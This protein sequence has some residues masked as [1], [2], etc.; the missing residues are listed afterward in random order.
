MLAMEL[1]LYRSSKPSEQPL[2]R[3]ITRIPSNHTIPLA[4]QNWV[5]QPNN[6]Q[7]EVEI[8]QLSA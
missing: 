2:G 6:Y 3:G 7:A 8:G 1:D 4:L 5:Q